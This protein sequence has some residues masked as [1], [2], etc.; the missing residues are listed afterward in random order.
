MVEELRVV[1]TGFFE[2]VGEDGQ[3]VVG[4]VELD[5][6]GD[7]DDRFGPP[8]GIERQR[9]INFWGS[10]VADFDRLRLH[11]GRSGS[12]G[13][14]E[15]C[16]ALVGGIVGCGHQY[17]PAVVRPVYHRGSGRC[18][19]FSFSAMGVSTTHTFDPSGGIFFS[20]ALK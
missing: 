6:A 10:R 19:F 3:A 15:W 7:G 18:Y 5:A 17:G 8:L 20:M 16:A 4:G 11:C 13:L 2:G 14:V 1:A 9:V 12:L